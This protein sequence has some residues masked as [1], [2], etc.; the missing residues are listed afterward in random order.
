[1]ELPPPEELPYEN[2]SFFRVLFQK[3]SFPQIVE[4]FTHLLF[5]ENVLLVSQSTSDLLPLIFALKSFIYPLRL[6]IF[7]PHL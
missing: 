1:M 2:P 7:V 3:L 4:I 5:E 6:G